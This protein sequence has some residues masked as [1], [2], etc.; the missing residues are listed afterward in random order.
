M[1]RGIDT[2]RP[3]YHRL[4]HHRT[5][6]VIQVA[7]N[8]LSAR[9]RA[10]N[11]I[12]RRDWAWH[13]AR[14]KAL[15]AR[16]Y[17]EAKLDGNLTL[18]ANPDDLAVGKTVFLRGNWEPAETDFIKRYV[19]PGMMVFDIGA[20][21]GAH[22]LLIAKQVGENGH[23]HAFEPSAANEYLSRN[24][25]VNQFNNTTVNAVALSDKPGTLRLTRALP[26]LE[27][28]SS[29][30]R[31]TFTESFSGF[32]DAPAETL[33][34][35]VSQYQIPSID[36]AKMDV[37]GAEIVILKGAQRI[38]HAGIIKAWLFEINAPILESIGESASEL[39]HLFESANYQLFL[40]SDTGQPQP[41]RSSDVKK[42]R[43][44][45]AL[46][47]SILEDMNKMDGRWGSAFK[48]T[49]LPTT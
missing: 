46:H 20:N 22:T 15:E 8:L 37:E 42:N 41:F 44:V 6:L 47:P 7:R 10:K 33:D 1:K 16:C 48:N 18:F 4:F 3:I 36:L 2:F 32:Y 12:L 26:G 34:D 35:Y 23:V 43:N 24:V 9:G 27:A 11:K 13:M 5:R 45:L 21:I 49:V 38:L 31:P 14:F 39:E 28:F 25:Q 30:G 17:L 29:V 40:L 19:K